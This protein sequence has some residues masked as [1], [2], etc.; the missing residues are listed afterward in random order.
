MEEVKLRQGLLQKDIKLRK[1]HRDLVIAG[2]IT[3]EE[4]WQ[5]RQVC[6]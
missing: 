5:T 3:E 1:L 6:Q 4:F 2:H